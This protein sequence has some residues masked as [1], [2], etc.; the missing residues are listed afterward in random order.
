MSRRSP[1]E[2]PLRGRGKRDRISKSRTSND[3]KQK[4]ARPHQSSRRL[5]RSVTVLAW[6]T[7][8]A[9]IAAGWYLYDLPT[10]AEITQ[11]PRQPCITILDRRGAIVATYGDHFATPVDVRTLPDSITKALIAIEDRRFFRHHGLDGRAILRALSVNLRALAWR[12]GASTLTQQLAK[13]L[14]LAAGRFRPA[15][16][17]LRRKLQ[18]L[19]LT[20]ILEARFSKDQILSLYLN[21]VYF[22]QG[23]YGLNAAAR[24]YFSKT[25]RDLSL[26][27]ASLL[28][29]LVQAPSRLSPLTAF[30]AAHARAT[31]V[32][33]AMVQCGFITRVQHDR[34][35]QDAVTSEQ[36]LPTLMNARYMS[37]W[38]YEQIPR[39]IDD[40]T[41]DL[42]V[43]T[44]LDPKMQAAAFSATQT[45]TAQDTPR[46]QCALVALDN[47]GAI[48]AMIGGSHDVVAP[49]NRAAHAHRQPG[50]AFKL[51]VFLAGLE[52][53]YDT[54]HLI[55]DGPV[56]VGKWAPKNFGWR[57]KG[58]ITLSDALAHSVNT[59]A[60]RLAQN[61][62]IAA[63][64]DVAHRLGIASPLTHDLSLAL[65]TSEVTL[66]ELT[67]CYAA[68]AAEGYRVRPYGIERIVTTTGHVMYQRP[69]PPAVQV[70]NTA[71]LSPLRNML[72]G[73][74][75]H[76]T[77]RKVSTMVHANPHLLWG[78]KT[79]TTQDHRDAWFIGYAGT[80][81]A[82]VWIGRDDSHPMSRIAGGGLPVQI[83]QKFMQATR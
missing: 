11:T 7:A 5:I 25:A 61:V 33:E 30:S 32:L 47:T 77:A 35:L 17:S 29:G 71:F 63:I 57:S 53:G 2:N 80:L 49:F 55:A 42:V 56:R 45:F 31:M 37:D 18:E 39:Y 24:R 3:S 40:I 66:L 65:G 75:T 1:P 15:D 22:G 38:V 10:L 20:F 74:L 28:A 62:G 4:P 72:K 78:G 23:V 64:H 81:T 36:R 59:S 19:V 83:W 8:C 48:R 13:T 14:L 82:G 27:E 12:Q 50:S 51:F 67:A 60:V 46:P 21:R 76:G 9:V 26:F 44:T 54:Q 34:A 16:R 69:S 73:V 58:Q 43:H 41:T 68:I 79:G 52:K 70:I 6:V